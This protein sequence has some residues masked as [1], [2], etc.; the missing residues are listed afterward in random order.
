MKFR[1]LAWGLALASAVVTTTLLPRAAEA[2]TLHVEVNEEG[3]DRVSIAVPFALA[4]IGLAIAGKREIEIESGDV[5]VED[6]RALWK[7]L[8][9]SGGELRADIVSDG[10]TVKIRNEKGRV[11]VHV[12][13]RAGDTVKIAVPEAAVDALFAGQNGLDVGAALAALEK[14]HSGDLVRIEDGRDSVHIWID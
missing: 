3:G 2:K 4:K 14:T 7:E 11:T 13:G 10:E 12:N 1:T 9:A 8:R 6:L 5:S